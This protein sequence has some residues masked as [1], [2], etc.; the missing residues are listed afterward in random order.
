[1]S[2]PDSA[3]PVATRALLR[4][5]DSELACGASVD[6]VLAQVADDQADR[7]TEHQQHCPH[8]QAAITEL[9]AL[10]SPVHHL[11]R[12]PVTAPQQLR[13]TVMRHID[14]LVDDVWYTLQLNAGGAI[15]VAARVVAG[16]A[17]EAAAG[18]PGVRVALGRST[19]S[20]IAAMVRTA[21][22]RHRHPHAAVGVLGS[23][24]VIDL[25]L[26]VTYNQPVHDVARQVQRRVMH[27]LRDTVGLQSITV[28][29][30]VDDVLP[31]PGI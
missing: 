15:R 26:A 5:T 25:A 1:M 30:T 22:H 16:I 9:A 10:W 18:V 28:N 27:E 13:A 3:R 7:L 11:A 4:A 24:A 6:D 20:R 29:V 19:D 23:A 12:E 8:C 14:R 31:P 21:T 2:H 17:R